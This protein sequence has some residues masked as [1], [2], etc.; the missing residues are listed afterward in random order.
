MKARILKLAS[1]TFCQIESTGEERTFI[2]SIL[3]PGDAK[4]QDGLLQRA[5]EFDRKAAQYAH[6]AALCREAAQ[7]IK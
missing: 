7:T 5:E 2:S 1:G 4:P 6:K 3:L